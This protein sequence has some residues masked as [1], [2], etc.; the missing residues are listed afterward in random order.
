MR[1]DALQLLLDYPWPGN[2]RELEHCIES[3][4]IFADREIS[5]ST[6]SLPRPGTTR[7]VRALSAQYLET[8]GGRGGGEEDDRSSSSPPRG[9]QGGDG[10]EGSAASLQVADEPSL[11]ELEARYIRHLLEVHDGNR[12]ECARILDIG[13]N[14]LI[15]KIKEYNID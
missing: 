12:S 6:L 10:E 15:R 9:V 13:R 8:M 7:R 2:V 1:G 4:V 14:T 5:P 11:R 3:A